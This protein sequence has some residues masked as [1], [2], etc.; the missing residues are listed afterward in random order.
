MVNLV[1]GR[2]Y[3]VGLPVLLVYGPVCSISTAPQH[4]N[5][6]IWTNTTFLSLCDNR[7]KHLNILDNVA[8]FYS[9]LLY[10]AIGECREL[11][12]KSISVVFMIAGGTLAVSHSFLVG[13]KLL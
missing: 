12:E 2:E 8:V 6:F 11:T 13:A 4:K 7:Q 9:I 5:G 3:F 10:G 1:R